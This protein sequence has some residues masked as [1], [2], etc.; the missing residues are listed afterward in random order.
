[1]G[2]VQGKN[3]MQTKPL[4]GNG[5]SNSGRNHHLP[6]EE[7]IPDTMQAKQIENSWGK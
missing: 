6:V 3:N 7:P 1:M 5:P 4:P 2:C